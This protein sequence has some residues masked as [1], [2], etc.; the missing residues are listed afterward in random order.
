MVR[1]TVEKYIVF[2]KAGLLEN[3]NR[4][5]ITVCRVL[6]NPQRKKPKNIPID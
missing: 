2:W 5:I 3:Q 6:L 4:A 1:N